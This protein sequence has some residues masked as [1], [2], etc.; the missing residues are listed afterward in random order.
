[1]EADEERE[2]GMR[3]EKR[4]RQAVRET[5]DGRLRLRWTPNGRVCS[6]LLLVLCNDAHKHAYGAHGRR[7]AIKLTADGESRRA[8]FRQFDHRLAA[9]DGVRRD[10]IRVAVLEEQTLLA[11]HVARRKLLHDLLAPV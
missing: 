7:H 5:T 2:R 8:M 1:M 10:S 3:R 9:A 11:V 6:P 4:G